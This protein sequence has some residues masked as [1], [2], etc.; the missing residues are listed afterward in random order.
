MSGGE[1]GTNELKSQLA[2]AQRSLA[3]LS[4]EVEELKLAV[5]QASLEAENARKVAA[6]EAARVETLK[7]ELEVQAMRSELTL[8]RSLEKL[9][10]DHQD[11][12]AK[13]AEVKIA[14]QKRMDLCI[15]DL[16]DSYQAERQRLLEKITT[17]ESSSA[18][19]TRDRDDSLPDHRADIFDDPLLNSDSDEGS[20]RVGVAITGD[21]VEEAADIA[22]ITSITAALVIPSVTSAVETVVT[23]VS[24]TESAVD[25]RNTTLSGLVIPSSVVYSTPPSCTDVSTVSTAL[26]TSRLSAIAEEFVPSLV[27]RS[28]S[29]VST[30]HASVPTTMVGVSAS[31]A[32]ASTSSDT[33]VP[34]VCVPGISVPTTSVHVTTTCMSDGTSVGTKEA[35]IPVPG[36]ASDGVMEYVTKLLKVQTDVMAAQARA[37]AVQNL[38]GLPYFT[39]E[40]TGDTGNGFDR[41][42]ERF[43]ERAEF[44][45]WT[46]EEQLY[47]LKVHL[48]K[49][50]LDV[51][52]MLPDYD[53]GSFEDVVLALKKRFRPEDIEELRGLEFHYRAQGDG[54]PI[55]QLGISIQQLGRKAFPSITGKD[56]DRLLKGR[57]YQA[58]LV[59]WQRKLSYPKPDEGF[60]EL[61]ARARMLE[62]HE[63]QFALSAQSRNENKKGSSEHSRRQNKPAD[64]RNSTSLLPVNKS[65]EKEADNHTFRCYSCKQ[66]GHL[67]KDCPRKTEAPGRTT[68]GATTGSV[69]VK[70]S[71][72]VV[73]LTESQLEDMLAERR[74]NREQQG[75]VE[76]GTDSQTSAIKASEEKALAVGALLH[77]NIDLEGLP[78][79]AMVD[80]GAQSTIISRSTLHAVNHHLKQQGENLPPLELPTV[81]LYGKDGQ[82]GGKQLLVITAQITLVLSLGDRSVQVPVFVQ[83]DSE[84]SCL[85]GINAIPHLGINVSHS[86]GKPVVTQESIS[87]L[88]EGGVNEVCL[89]KGVKLPA[90]K[91]R[92][93]QAKLSSPLSD[94]TDLLFEPDPELLEQLG[95]VALES[96]VA[97]QDDRDVNI[98]VQNFQGVTVHLEAGTRLGTVCSL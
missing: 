40:G 43:R 20:S 62:E 97:I 82:K 38:P 52:R 68:H 89:E 30:G 94:F 96:V 37:V 69:G 34:S 95:I 85:L 42:L 14:E 11:I 2:G 93:L 16:K 61:L 13:E 24:R 12:L 70:A 74:L 18:V 23:G 26:T 75:L 22:A 1:T 36:S 72:Q 79:K 45:G 54:E 92:V 15:Q 41:W 39:G 8:L 25:L 17:L 29:S 73:D 27:S 60:H 88:T 67:R 71:V 80:T 44:A 57:F 63:K 28:V 86:D 10:S 7:Q 9:R 98:P 35:W 21:G 64:K 83:P 53:C 87:S 66:P 6:D 50:A 55:E 47:Q 33:C 56:F 46:A 3:A 32:D 81:R 59:K 19:V 76:T 84:Q 90:Q 58:L 5:Q 78:V 49:T 48:D 51:L 91:G 4:E 65:S 77:M 31:T